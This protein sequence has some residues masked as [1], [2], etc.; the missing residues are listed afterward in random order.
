MVRQ[1]EHE[2]TNPPGPVASHAIHQVLPV[3]CHAS[4]HRILRP[5]R[6]DGVSFS[7]LGSWP[8]PACTWLHNPEK[9]LQG[10]LK[11]TTETPLEFT[12]IHYATSIARILPVAAS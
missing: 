12:K 6:D 1:S 3:K 10:L 5:G 4:V 2:E 11:S 7:V 8:V 9:H